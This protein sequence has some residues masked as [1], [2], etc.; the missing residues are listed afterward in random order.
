MC[1]ENVDNS[2]YENHLAEKHPD[3]QLGWATEDLRSKWND[4]KRREQ[5]IFLDYKED[6]N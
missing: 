6:S 5:D 1:S 4:W 2:G 3:F